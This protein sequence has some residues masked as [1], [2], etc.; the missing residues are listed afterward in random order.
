MD[1]HEY[2]RQ[3]VAKAGS[4]FYYSVRTLPPDRQ[5]AA[6]ALEA[7]RREV[8]AV[9]NEVRDPGV[10]RTKLAYWHEELG[11][12]YAG[13][14][15]HP[16]TRALAEAV[17]TYGIDRGALDEVI[18][19]A[20]MDL[21][22]NAYPDFDA[23]QV[24]CRRVRGVPQRLLSRIFGFEDAKTLEHAEQ[25]GIALELTRCA[26]D[27]G[28]DARRGRVYLPLHDMA[29]H[30]VTSDDLAHARETDASKSLI[31]AEIARADALY[32]HAQALLPPADR[33]SQRPGLVMAAIERALLREI[34]ADGCRVLTQRTS[35]TPLRMLWIA[36]RTR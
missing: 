36:M 31:A 20:G 3:K 30:G 5:R 35:L 7:F 29:E 24:Y 2:C 19:G 10:A 6:I 4:A 21:E 8:T 18:Q 25:L 9:A 17:V 28:E 27:V 1:P 14:P 16:V 13:K 22:Y 23:L 12:L 32:D 33:K 15:L 26:R 34:E 11:R